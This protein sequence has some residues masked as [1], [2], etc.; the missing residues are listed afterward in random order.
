MHPSKALHG[1]A[2]PAPVALP[3]CDHYAGSEALLVKSLALQARLGPVFDITADCEDS[4][5]GHEA[6]HAAMVGALSLAR[7]SVEAQLTIEGRPYQAR[8]E[9]V[10]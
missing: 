1:K 10:F 8:F 7:V 5:P 4:P 3:V 6:A 9:Y 2:E